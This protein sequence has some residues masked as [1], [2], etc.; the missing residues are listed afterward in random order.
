MSKKSKKKAKKKCGYPDVELFE[1]NYIEQEQPEQ[2]EQSE[3]LQYPEFQHNQDRPDEFDNDSWL[4]KTEEAASKLLTNVVMQFNEDDEHT[5]ESDVIVDLREDEDSDEYY[6]DRW[7][8]NLE[9]ISG[10]TVESVFNSLEIPDDEVSTE[11][12]VKAEAALPDNNI[13]TDDNDNVHSEKGSKNGIPYNYALRLLEQK[14]LRYIDSPEMS[15]VLYMFNGR[16]WEAVSEPMLRCIVYSMITMQKRYEEP[17][18]RTYCKEILDYVYLECLER[19]Y[20]RHFTEDDFD[21]VKNHIVLNNGIYDVQSGVFY[22]DYFDSS[23][24]YLSAINAYFIEDDDVL[25]TPAYDALKYN[26]ANGDTD[27]ME[28]VDLMLAYLV[29]PNMTGKV[30]FCMSFSPNSGKT[31]LGHFLTTLLP[32]NLTK[33][34]EPEKLANRFSMAD[35]GTKCLLTCL[36]MSTGN[37]D[38]NTVAAIKRLT[39]EKFIRSEAKFRGEKSARVRAKLLFATNGKIVIPDNNDEA[40]YKRLRVVPFVNSIPDDRL[41]VNLLDKLKAERSAIMTKCLLKL[42]NIINPDGKIVFPESRMSKEMKES[43]RGEPRFESVF[44]DQMLEFTA[45]DRDVVFKQDLTDRYTMFL[46]DNDLMSYTALSQNELASRCKSHF[47]GAKVT[48][49][50]RPEIGGNPIACF[51]GLRWKQ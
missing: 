49:K 33:T 13:N 47:Q 34:I 21:S 36:E 41:D 35:I 30:F 44:F 39:G 28:M 14:Q 50:R 46:A 42:S 43:W 4:E 9:R 29:L 32:P 25:S 24:P 40:F 7:A 1:S 6:A 19:Y 22:R 16:Y 18:I 2:L 26:A 11:S 27:A 12:A 37:F 10:E 3:Q 8:K 23:L 45:S 51:V 15:D 5:D 48:K 20:L 38:K 31:L 17:K